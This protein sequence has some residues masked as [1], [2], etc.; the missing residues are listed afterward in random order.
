MVTLLVVGVLSAAPGW[1]L[2]A[3]ACNGT[4]GAD[5]EVLNALRLEL[6]MAPGEPRSLAVR[7]CDDGKW[8]VSVDGNTARQVDVSTF[9]ARLRARTFA[10]LVTRLLAV[11]PAQTVPVE[12]RLLELAD[13]ARREGRLG[14]AAQLLERAANESEQPDAVVARLTLDELQRTAPRSPA[15]DV[16]VG[17]RVYFGQPVTA[18]TGLAARGCFWRVCVALDALG[19]AAST[20]YSD[21]SGGLLLGSLGARLF[22]GP[23]SLRPWLLE[24]GVEGGGVLTNASSRLSGFTGS[25]AVNWVLGGYVR[26]GLRFDLARWVALVFDLRAGFDRGVVVTVLDA[27]ELAISGPFASLHAGLTF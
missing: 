1:Q 14:A 19:T 3:S 22:D 25:T 16:M 10:L 5:A 13:A 4:P 12:P 11:P 20:R 24:V 7:V 21:L 26:T 23:P 15:F 17:V 2:S 6:E 9:P 18:T 8:W 27:P